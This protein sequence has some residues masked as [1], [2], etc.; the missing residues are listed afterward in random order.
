MQHPGKTLWGGTL[1]LT[2]IPHPGSGGPAPFLCY[3]DGP[4][5]SSRL[6]VLSGGLEEGEGAALCQADSFIKRVRPNLPLGT[7]CT[8][9][10]RSPANRIKSRLPSNVSHK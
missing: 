9:R 2:P 4:S 7:E 5:P 6:P 8:W 3:Q 1:G 10:R